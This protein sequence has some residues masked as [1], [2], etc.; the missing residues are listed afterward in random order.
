MFFVFENSWFWCSS[1]DTKFPIW[2]FDRISAYS[3]ILRD[4]ASGS[5]LY[6]RART[7]TVRT[8]PYISSFILSK[9]YRPILALN[10]SYE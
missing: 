3:F 9:L 10:N 6:K 8:K 4:K 2:G 7:Y 1:R 5:L